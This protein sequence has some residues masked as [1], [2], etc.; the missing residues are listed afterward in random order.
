[1]ANRAAQA[2]Q[3]PTEVDPKAAKSLL[4]ALSK[5][6][7]GALG[8]ADL[9]IAFAKLVSAGQEESAAL[10]SVLT[11]AETL[12]VSRQ[13]LADEVRTY[14]STL[15]AEGE[16]FERAKAQKLTAGMN[17][18]QTAVEQLEQEL[19]ELRKQ[20]DQLARQM[21]KSEA[22]LEKHRSNMEGLQAKVAR[23]EEEFN[24]ARAYLRSEVEGDLQRLLGQAD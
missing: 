18:E 17:A 20:Q 1:M 3:F 5:V 11:T 15:E 7:Q 24:A 9:R 23:R 6:K 2:F 10:E 16:A 8:Y 13:Q 4:S 12:G 21:K 19:R 14:L 22:K